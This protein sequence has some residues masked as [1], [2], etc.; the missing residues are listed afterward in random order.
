MI[1]RDKQDL[2][3][4]VKQ[5]V[6]R[7]EVIDTR[8]DFDVQS[9]EVGVGALMGTLTSGEAVLG[10][11]TPLGSD[12]VEAFAALDALDL[13]VHD[14]EKA[15]AIAQGYDRQSYLAQVLRAAHIRRVLVSVPLAQ[16]EQTA[17]ADNRFAPLLIV[18]EGAFAPGRYGVD[19]QEVA[20]RIA[21]AAR[22]CGAKDV[23]LE[24]WDM[25]AAMYCLAPV[26][27]DECLV[28]HVRLHTPGQVAQLL[29]TMDAHPGLRV[30][31]CG[32]DQAERALLEASAENR[33]LLVRLT[34]PRRLGEAVGLL[35]TRVLAYSACAKL[36]EQMLGRWVCVKELVW[37]AL[38]EAYLP[39]ARA[40]YD[41]TDD[42]VERDAARMLGG[43]YEELYTTVYEDGRY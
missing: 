16:A 23:S 27:E 30:L 8:L 1:I 15:E 4:C 26:C 29:Q 35:G 24:T 10:S 19:Y 7:A 34:N 20:Q 21:Q 2:R 14:L 9:G 32:R 42:A 5:A 31:A 40:G 38:Y 39:L 37:Q 13:P 12:A 33:Q 22:A 25:Q 28:L 3:R 17:F 36:P 18:G 11:G 43:A 6:R 41:L